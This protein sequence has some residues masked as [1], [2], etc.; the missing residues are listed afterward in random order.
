MR[1][2]PFLRVGA[3]VKT[4][5]RRRDRRAGPYYLLVV[6]EHGGRQRSVYLG[7][8]G[9]LVREVERELAAF[10]APHRERRQ[11]AHVRGQLH[12]ELAKARR[13]LNAQLA[14]IG[15]RR[16]GSEIRGWSR[17]VA[18]GHG[19]WQSHGEGADQRA[20]PGK[21]AV[22]KPRSDKSNLLRIQR[23][24]SDRVGASSSRIA[25]PSC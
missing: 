16:Q 21:S 2:A 11:L 4:W 8:A 1:T 6:R 20:V 13:Q 14:E 7:P 19:I 23:R 3:I 25:S 17:I 18:A 24:S 9:V 15:L 12:V 22:M 10:R 5:R